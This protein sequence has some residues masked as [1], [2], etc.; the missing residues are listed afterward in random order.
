MITRR[1]FATTTCATVIWYGFAGRLPGGLNVMNLPRRR[2][3]LPLGTIARLVQVQK[4]R[5]TS[6]ATRGALHS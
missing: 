4:P 6:G 3:D 2:L 5:G 1:E